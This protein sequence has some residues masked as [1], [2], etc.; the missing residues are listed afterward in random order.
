[1]KSSW[2]HVLSVA[3][4]ATGF[5]AQPAYAAAQDPP[6][7]ADDTQAARGTEAAEGEADDS[8]FEFSGTRCAPPCLA[9]G[10][11]SHFLAC[12][13]L[14]LHGTLRSRFDVTETGRKASHRL[15]S[16]F[17]QFAGRCSLTTQMGNFG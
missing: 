2:I 16:P 5:W 6:A 9:L 15:S 8:K 4:L 1:M 12:G 11:F 3:L 10:N 13:P 17:D 7:P 14:L